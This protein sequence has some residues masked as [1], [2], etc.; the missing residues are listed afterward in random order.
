MDFIQNFPFFS[1]VLSLFCSVVAFGFKGKKARFTT[2]FLLGITAIMSFSVIVYNYYTGDGYFVYRMGHYDAPIGNE[3]SAGLLE[4]FFALLFEI[5]ILLSIIGGAKKIFSDTEDSKHKFFYIMVNLVHAALIALCYTND[6][7]TAY[8]FIEI[9]TIASCSLLMLRSSGKAL[10]AATRYMIFSLIGSAFTLIGIILLYSITGHLLFPQLYSTLQALWETGNYTIPLTMALGLLISGLAI[11]SGLF[12]FHFWMPDTYGTATPAA[13]GILS[14]VVSKGYIF[15][16]FKII[17]RVIGIEIFLDSGIQYLIFILGVLGMIFGSVAAINAKNINYMVAFS[18]AS[19]IGYIYMGLGL[20]STAAFLASLFQ[21]TAHSLTKPM[22]FLSTSGL[23]ETVNGKQGFS[24]IT[25]SG[26]NNKIAG[27]SF[28]A[29]ALS[30]IGIPIF[31]GFVPKFLFSTASFNHGISTYI[32]LIALAISTILNVIYFLRTT[33]NLFSP[34]KCDCERK[35]ITFSQSKAFSIV[36]LVMTAVNIAVGLHSQPLITL[37]EKGIE[38]FS[39]I[40]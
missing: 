13:S 26:H 27:F 16:L 6:I 8:V 38:I 34:A 19:Q 30:M 10:A 17:Y 5:V 18:S 28:S 39:N 23:S 7:F 2:Y 31:A 25:S 14:G 37:F 4:P 32:V 33:L 1:I 24:A 15:L 11:K 12:P 36:V 9:C 21:I 40:H 22:F 29:G 3:I 20:G 35:N